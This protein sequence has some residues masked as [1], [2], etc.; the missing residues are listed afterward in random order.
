MHSTFIFLAAAIIS[1]ASAHNAV[2]RREVPAEQ[3][4]NDHN[5]VSDQKMHNQKLERE[6]V[7]AERIE[8]HEGAVQKQ[9]AESFEGHGKLSIQRLQALQNDLAAD[10]EN[11]KAKQ[12]GGAVPAGPTTC[13]RNTFVADWGS[14]GARIFLAH[15]AKNRTDDAEFKSNF[16][17]K[18]GIADWMKYDFDEAGINQLF[19]TLKANLAQNQ[20]ASMAA[21]ATAG[22]RL[23]RQKSKLVWA[24]LAKANTKLPLFQ[25]CGDVGDKKG[26]QTLPGATEA[27]YEYTSAFQHDTGSKLSGMISAGGAS[28]QMTFKVA[29][30]DKAAAEKCVAQITAATQATSGYVENASRYLGTPSLITLS[31]LA[32]RFED[33]PGLFSVGGS[34]EMRASFDRQLVLNKAGVTGNF[35]Q[36]WVDRVR[37]ATERANFPKHPCL[38]GPWPATHGDP[39]ETHMQVRT[40]TAEENVTG[41][42]AEGPEYLGDKFH[43]F[44]SVLKGDDQATTKKC[45]EALKA[46]VVKDFMTTAFLDG[47][48]KTLA[49]KVKTWKL[50]SGVGRTL[51]DMGGWNDKTGDGLKKAWKAISGYDF[52]SH[53]YTPSSKA[54]PGKDNPET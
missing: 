9:G 20:D 40:D 52:D 50:I 48:C 32:V 6:A 35:E 22:N 45:G 8:R 41:A 27:E 7:W 28:L 25:G 37:S 33:T 23:Q 4:R 2:L 15:H 36:A 17:E 1:A 18:I 24:A 3:P 38:N 26:C 44:Y 34:N 10:I 21:M 5:E 49:A 30:S 47:D 39:A 12:P 13:W 31:W 46:F 16:G 19:T 29:A 51:K 14:T 11:A 43:S 54:V 53:T 42:G